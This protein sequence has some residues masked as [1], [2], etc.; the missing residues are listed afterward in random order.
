[1]ECVTRESGKGDT[2]PNMIARRQALPLA[3]EDFL[4]RHPV[5]RLDELAHALGREGETGAALDRVKHHLGR[6]RLKRVTRG[7]YAAV[8]R[9]TSARNFVPDRY[10]VAA[11]A[12]PDGILS[13][14]A[15]LELLG[16]AHSEWNLCTVLC[17]Q[18]RKPFRVGEA[19]VR[20][21]GHPASLRRAGKERLGAR[22]TERAGRTIHFTGPERSLVDG[23][24]Q[25]RLVGGLEEH[26][27]STAG[28]GVLDLD[29]LREILAAYDQKGLWA[30]VG[31][32][33]ERH[34]ER[35][36]VPESL[37]ARLEKKRPLSP[38]YVPRGQRGGVL[39]RRWNL[40]LPESLS[41]GW[42]GA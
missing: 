34:R 29:L 20:F 36:F 39:S 32:F 5:F 21:L 6:G 41:G 37:L 38:H 3:T 24:R 22:L 9:G 26:V 15:A 27:E 42:E 19:E 23:F 25:P 31:W 18:R 33:L 1:L 35:F 4:A 13:H 7:L 16:V 28:L 2:V 12:S 30:C 40:V 10:A 14:H 8:P 11:A 17:S